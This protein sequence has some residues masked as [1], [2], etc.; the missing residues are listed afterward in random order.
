MK[1]IEAGLV[2]LSSDNVKYI[3]Y[4]LISF[5][6]QKSDLFHSRRYRTVPF[7]DKAKNTLFFG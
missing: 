7:G 3:A 2:Y 5:E 6:A 1:V 4:F